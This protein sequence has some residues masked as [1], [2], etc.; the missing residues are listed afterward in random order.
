M[1]H[2]EPSVLVD[3]GGIHTVKNVAAEI[4]SKPT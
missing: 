2:D 4:H 1:M 3:G